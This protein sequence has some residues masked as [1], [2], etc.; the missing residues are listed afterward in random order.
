[1]P[2]YN[3][4]KFLAE[5]I[6]SILNQ[7]YTDFEFLIIDDGSTDRAPEIIHSY[8]D[9]RIRYFRN[10]QNLGITKSLNLGIDLAKGE[11]IARMDADD[12]SYPERL[13][14]QFDFITNHSD[15]DFFTCYAREVSEDLQF[16]CCAKYN[17]NYYFH[18]ITFCCWIYHPTMVYK[19][20]AVLSIGKYSDMYSEDFELAWKITRRF[21]IYHLPEILLDYRINSLSLWQVTK[22]KEYKEAFLRQVR[23]NILYYL[24]NDSNISLEAW[25]LELLSYNFDSLNEFS[26]NQIIASFKLQDL[27][28][29]KMIERDNPNRNIPI[30]I[31]ANKEKKD[32]IIALGLSYFPIHKSCMF[33]LKLGKGHYIPKY[34]FEKV[35]KF[36]FTQ[37]NTKGLPM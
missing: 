12:I 24:G 25:K 26:V 4:E 33:L 30:L 3:S 31:A 29:K 7:T 35:A 20:G 9:S 22:K 11:Y 10:E 28:T 21:K 27:V 6:E 14:K 32:H 37:M 5:A 13:Q 15:G 1:M 23:R 17:P 34:F 8:L 19:K 2:V 36:N 16:V 18:S